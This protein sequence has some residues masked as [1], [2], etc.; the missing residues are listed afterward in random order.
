MIRRPPRSTLFPSPPLFRSIVRATPVHLPAGTHGTRGPGW[1]TRR[2][3]ARLCCTY[4][5]SDRLCPRL[6]RSDVDSPVVV[7][8]DP[9][10][11]LKV[12]EQLVYLG[13]KLFWRN[14]LLSSAPIQRQTQ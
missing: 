11:G 3:S 2:T 6:T 1:S 5:Q 4:S 9:A 8:I 12:R 7:H 13:L 14:R 10:L